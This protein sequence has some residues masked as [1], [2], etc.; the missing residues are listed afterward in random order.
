MIVA[1]AKDL[2]VDDDVAIELAEDARRDVLE[3]FVVAVS[4]QVR[5]YVSESVVARHRGLCTA[6]R[7]AKL[8]VLKVT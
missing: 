2:R 6:G 7:A 8:V 3:E 4:L 5:S 1:V